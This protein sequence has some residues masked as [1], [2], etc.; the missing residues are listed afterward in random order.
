MKNPKST[1]RLFELDQQLESERQ[2]PPPPTESSTSGSGSLFNLDKAVGKPNQ[3]L[4]PRNHP[5]PPSPS[6]SGFLFDLDQSVAEPNQPPQSQNHPPQIRSFDDGSPIEMVTAE[7]DNS[8]MEAQAFDFNEPIVVQEENYTKASSWDE[9]YTEASPWDEDH[10]TASSGKDYT[11]EMATGSVP[12]EATH[13]F[14]PEQQVSYAAESPK[15][16]SS[17][18]DSLAKEMEVLRQKVRSLE[19]P[20]ASTAPSSPDSEVLGDR[21]QDIRNEIKQLQWQKQQQPKGNT[22]AIADQ[23]KAI[24]EELQSLR[25]SRED[26]HLSQEDWEALELEPTFQDFD[27]KID[28][29]QSPSKLEAAHYAPVEVVPPEAPHPQARAMEVGLS[30]Q[31][32][33]FDRMMDEETTDAIE[34]AEGLEYGSGIGSKHYASQLGG[35]ETIDMYLDA[36]RTG[37]RDS[38]AKQ[39]SSKLVSGNDLNQWTWGE[40]SKGAIILYQGKKQE[41]NEPD[42]NDDSQQEQQLQLAPLVLYPRFNNDDDEKETKLEGILQVSITDHDRIQIYNGIDSDAKKLPEPKIDDNGKNYQYTL[43]TIPKSGIVLGIAAKRYNMSEKDD[44][45]IQLIFIPI[46]NGTTKNHQTAQ[47]MVAPWMMADVSLPT[48]QVYC[49]KLQ[50]LPN[51]VNSSQSEQ[52]IEWKNDKLGEIKLENDSKNKNQGNKNKIIRHK[53]NIKFIQELSTILSHADSEIELKEIP[54][55]SILDV[56]NGFTQDAVEIGYSYMPGKKIH[57]SSLRSPQKRWNYDKLK[58]R[59]PNEISAEHFT[60]KAN[61]DVST[62]SFGNL[63]VTPPFKGYPWGRIYYSKGNIETEEKN[64]NQDNFFE[65]YE[66]FLKAQKVQKPFTLDASWLGVGHV[67]EMICF[68]PGK[69]KLIACVASPDLAI[70]IMTETLKNDPNAEFMKKRKFKWDGN[71]ITSQ[72]KVSD[73]LKGIDK[74]GK[75]FSDIKKYN[76][77]EVNSKISE[78]VKK[79]RKEIDKKLLTIVPIPVIF[80]KDGKSKRA[81]AL[82]SNMVNMLV[83]NGYCIFPKPYGPSLS[84]NDKEKEKKKKFKINTKFVDDQKPWASPNNI[85]FTVQQNEDVFEQYM[86]T[87]L[88][89]L[90]F[91]SSSID[92]WDF[93]HSAS[94]EVHCATNA[95][96]QPVAENAQWWKFSK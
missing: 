30:Q 91:Q 7:E 83:V 22:E 85:E 11:K 4:Q 2:S 69:D 64:R 58:Y 87:I 13:S 53:A 35:V 90:G 29:E 81:T 70:K 80:E 36:N 59:F 54:V 96:R 5:S 75:K 55:D 93:C 82:T 43:D 1:N 34:L 73:F 61:R 79:L 77:N 12:F 46:V 23:I 6:G 76:E 27:Q 86:L 56:S 20:A 49:C 24:R 50:D 19:Q 17:H 10:T 95:L 3:P 89:E 9:D 92:A 21:L 62:M 14:E 60:S 16:T 78:M 37:K 65:D 41:N 42:N 32:A 18:D 84:T 25:Q 57:T 88:A 45:P 31:F 74:H 71:I 44:N 8:P 38:N 33:E 39:L 66:N 28:E 47:I 40:K 15:E 72:L 63:E 26:E 68:L 94:G 51:I 48:K 52:E 67:D